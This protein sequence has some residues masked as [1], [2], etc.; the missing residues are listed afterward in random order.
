[1]FGKEINVNDAEALVRSGFSFEGGKLS[2]ISDPEINTLSYLKP[3]ADSGL[4]LPNDVTLRDSTVP[5]DFALNRFKGSLEGASIDLS[6]KHGEDAIGANQV[7]RLIN[8]DLGTVPSN[9]GN[10]AFVSTDTSVPVQ[11]GL[12]INDDLTSNTASQ[13]GALGFEQVVGEINVKSSVKLIENSDLNLSEV[14]VKGVG[15]VNDFLSI[16]NSGN[17]R[18]LE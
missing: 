11:I 15:E 9:N 2:S 7:L 16:I 1:M 18:S 14:K 12:T 17:G 8:R 5:L 10:K 6:A 3:L 13:L 4:G